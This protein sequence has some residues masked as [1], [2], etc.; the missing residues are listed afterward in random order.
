MNR[1]RLVSLGVLSAALTTGSYSGAE[2]EDLSPLKAPAWVQVS[3]DVHFPPLSAANHPDKI[4]VLINLGKLQDQLPDELLY[5]GREGTDQCTDANVYN[6]SPN[7]TK[8]PVSS[9]TTLMPRAIGFKDG[10]AVLSV[11]SSVQ[12]QYCLAIPK[13]KIIWDAKDVGFGIKTRVP[14]VVNYNDFVKANDNVRI[15]DRDVRYNITTDSGWFKIDMNIDP[16]S[17]KNMPQPL[18][19]KLG[20]LRDIL[21]QTLARAKI[22]D[23][24]PDK[25]LLSGYTAESG[26]FLMTDGNLSVRLTLKK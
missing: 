26:D 23:Q 4:E 22:I 24:S 7:T 12:S 13:T 16:N 6:G 10:S 20:S 21:N 9:I 14:S 8:T 18:A 2:S 25:A 15:D 17:A 11:Q 5:I 1:A 3:P 19:D